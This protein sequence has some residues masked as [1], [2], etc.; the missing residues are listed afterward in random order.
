[1]SELGEVRTQ[2]SEFLTQLK[3]V[4][5]QTRKRA[6]RLWDL[7]LRSEED[8][9]TCLEEVDTLLLRLRTVRMISLTCT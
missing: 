1:M 5:E 3:E 7:K 8:L 9:E 6:A 4:I 2:F